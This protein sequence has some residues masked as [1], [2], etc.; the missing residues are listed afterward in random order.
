MND[1]SQKEQIDAWLEE[2]LRFYSQGD[3]SR[4]LEAWYR[5]LDVDVGHALAQQYVAYVRQVY[6]LDAV[7]RPDADPP[8]SP[9]R[10]T[11]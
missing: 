3:P 8:G 2:G 10:S 5:I 9:T 4:A 6:R 1:G 7:A 11:Q